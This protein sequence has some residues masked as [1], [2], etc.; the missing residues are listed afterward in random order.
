MFKPDEMPGGPEPAHLSHL[1]VTY[2]TQSAGGTDGVAGL[3]A[4]WRDS[5]QPTLIRDDWRNNGDAVRHETP[6]K[7]KGCTYFCD[8]VK[9]DIPRRRSFM[10]WPVVRDDKRS[11]HFGREP[12]IGGE[13][14]NEYGVDLADAYPRELQPRTLPLSE[15]TV[16]AIEHNPQYT[17]IVV[18]HKRDASHPIEPAGSWF[19]ATKLSFNCHMGVYAKALTRGMTPYRRL[20]LH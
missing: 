17:T 1:R 8:L 14:W 4:P 9:A 19:R 3:V 20:P 10:G 5:N 12:K 7:W 6:Y 11:L 2:V 18:D 15:E 16:K 13:V